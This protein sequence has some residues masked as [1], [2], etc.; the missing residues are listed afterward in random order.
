MSVPDANQLIEALSDAA[1]ILKRGSPRGLRTKGKLVYLPTDFEAIIIGDLHGD[2]TSLQHILTTTWF[3]ERVKD[4]EP[5]MLVCMGDYIDRGPSQVEVLYTLTGLLVEHP[6]N[7]VLLRGNHEGPGDVRVRP[8]DF[9]QVLRRLYEEDSWQVYRS[10]RALADQLYTAAI[11]PGR[12]LVLHGGAPIES[13][14]LDDIAQAHRTH[15]EKDTLRQ[16]LW[17]DPVAQSGYTPSMRGVGYH[18]GPDITKRLLDAVHVKALIRGHQGS[19]TGYRVMGDV[20]TVY[21]C[22]LPHLDN[23]RAAYME[24]PYLHD[25]PENFTSYVKTF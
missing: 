2:Y 21:S 17:N 23:T 8:H 4:G 6:G 3:S 22:K 14:S 12:V 10:F 18:F 1:S 20:I 19:T 13:T 11:A 16:I 25:E 7:V 9:P 24:L 5:V 15:P